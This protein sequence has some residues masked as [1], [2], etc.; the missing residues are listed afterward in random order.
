MKV[1]VVPRGALAHIKAIFP[2]KRASYDS[3]AVILYIFS[4]K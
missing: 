1:A 4:I 2:R 3:I